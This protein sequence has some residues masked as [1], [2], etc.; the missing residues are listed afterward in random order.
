MAGFSMQLKSGC[1]SASPDFSKFKVTMQSVTNDHSYPLPR[2]L[3]AAGDTNCLDEKAC[4]AEIQNLHN[5]AMTYLKLF[6][7]QGSP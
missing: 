1:L 2:R 5:L 6:K 3:V 4:L 7:F